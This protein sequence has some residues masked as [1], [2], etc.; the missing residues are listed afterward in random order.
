MLEEDW[1]VVDEYAQFP[2]I[3]KQ[4]KDLGKQV[5]NDNYETYKIVGIP[6]NMMTNSIVKR[7]ID[8]DIVG[9]HDRDHKFKDE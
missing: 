3:K 7:S 8:E 2:G 4:I 9:D 5:K 6:P 1:D